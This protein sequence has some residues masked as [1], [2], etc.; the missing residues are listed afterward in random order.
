MKELAQDAVNCEETKMSILAR[1]I[2]TRCSQ[3]GYPIDPKGA[4]Q[5]SSKCWKR[6]NV[7][8][9]AG[10]KS[11]I[12]GHRQIHGTPELLQS[13]VPRRRREKTWKTILSFLF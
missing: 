10:G 13:L 3:N 12:I 4:L 1:S 11:S 5:V 7:D 8:S 9:I 2:Y 6:M